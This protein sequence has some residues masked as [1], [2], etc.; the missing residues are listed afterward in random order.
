VEYGDVEAIVNEVPLAEFENA[1]KGDVS[2]NLLWLES[3]ARAHDQVLKRLLSSGPVI[4]FRYCTVLRN[5]DDV[6]GMLSRHRLAIARTLDEFDGK[7]EWGVKIFLDR[8]RYA[9]VETRDADGEAG[10]KSYL[11]TKK[12]RRDEWG[13]AARAARADASDCH[14]QLAAVA[15]D[16]VTLPA[17]WPKDSSD[18]ELL[19][20]GAY[21]IADNALDR[22]RALIDT[23]A[24]AHAGLSSR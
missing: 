4:P 21:L 11:L 2:Q 24:A 9:R 22:F 16:A 8:S 1:M 18:A 19:V 23:L 15:A 12:R 14:Q 7:R 13:E 17:R 3:K 5:E 10:G 6:R 20:N